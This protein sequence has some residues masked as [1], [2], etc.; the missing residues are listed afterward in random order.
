M[1]AL[2]H[3]TRGCYILISDITA[4]VG[5]QQRSPLDNTDGISFTVAV[6]D[7]V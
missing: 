3:R 6:G 5:M 4:L 7:S 2:R 1:M